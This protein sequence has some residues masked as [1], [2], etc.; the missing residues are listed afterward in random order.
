MA[1]LL[2]DENANATLFNLPN[3]CP[4]VTLHIC[5][6]FEHTSSVVLEPLM[7]D[8]DLNIE[9]NGPTFVAD[10]V[11]PKHKGKGKM[12]APLFEADVRRSQ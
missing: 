2:S 10:P 11:T 9:D 3:A 5:S 12:K 8:Q 7:D 4:D 6:N 1:P